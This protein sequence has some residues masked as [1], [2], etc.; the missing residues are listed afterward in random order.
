MQVYDTHGNLLEADLPNTGSLRFEYNSNGQVDS[1]TDANQNVTTYG[2]DATTGD[3]TSVHSP[4]G[5]R[6]FTHNSPCP[7]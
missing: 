6:T 3:R 7:T 5:T 2:Y 1:F 4:A